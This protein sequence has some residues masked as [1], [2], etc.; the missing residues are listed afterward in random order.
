MS[1]VLFGF[2]VVY[3]DGNRLWLSDR[4]EFDI[5]IMFTFRFLTLRKYVV[6][7]SAESELDRGMICR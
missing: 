3:S 4:F 1:S 7:Q 6:E 5:V 2:S